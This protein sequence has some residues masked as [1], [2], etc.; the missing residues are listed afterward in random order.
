MAMHVCA[1]D[2]GMTP[3]EKP[4]LDLAGID[5]P[6]RAAILVE[7]LPYIQAFAGRTVVIKLG[8]STMGDADLFASFAVDV[9]LLR[10]AAPP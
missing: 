2:G 5:A 4:P 7:A 3:P 10:A 9:V 8:G 6:T 1:Y